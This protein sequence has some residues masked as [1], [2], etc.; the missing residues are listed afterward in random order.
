[1]TEKKLNKKLIVTSNQFGL[2]ESDKIQDSKD[3]ADAMEEFPTIVP[4]INP[5]PASVKSTLSGI[6]T[7][8]SKRK[9]LLEEAQGIT[10]L[11]NA[12]L[13]KVSNIFVDKWCKQIQDA[14]GIDANKVKQLKF[15][16]KGIYDG[17]SAP[18]VTVEN[19]HPQLNDLVE[20]SHLKHTVKM[21]NST[22]KEV[23]AP[24]DA[25]GTDLY[26][27]FGETPPADY[28][29]WKYLGRVKSGKYI[30][31]FTDA[32]VGKTVWYF[33]IYVPKKANAI[34]ETA[35]KVRSQVV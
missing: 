1:M 11:I 3:K 31:N 2:S 7:N 25:E 28:H 13:E 4:G 5:T 29:D 20:V 17:Q 34:P 19:S 18:V 6:D 26:M 32:D 10:G 9:L 15:G 16:V 14:S 12:D 8:V 27:V 24:D 30:V 21:V 23:A 33:A 35:G 22:T